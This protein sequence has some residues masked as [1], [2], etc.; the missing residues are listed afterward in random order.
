[1]DE[2]MRKLLY[3]NIGSVRRYNHSCVSGFNEAVYCRLR[4]QRL[5]YRLR[6]FANRKAWS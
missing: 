6:A 2:K 5:W 4:R 3:H 1:M